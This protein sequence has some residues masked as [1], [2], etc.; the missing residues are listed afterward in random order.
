MKIWFLETRPQF[1]LLSVVL[2]F[3][4]AS[5]AWY[6]SQELGIP[7]NLGYAFLAGFGLL[8]AHI[9]VNTLNDYFDYRSGVDLETRRTPFSGGSGV[10]PAALLKP[11]QV[12]WLGI[13]SFLLAIPI[14]IYFV[15]VSGWLLLPLLLI[16]AVCI[17]LS[18][19]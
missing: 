6:E 14:G 4:G 8:L 2:A 10:L 19:S 9:S 11:G 12:F 18:S 16:A 7:F 1:L 17:L 13:G 5:I 15:I 3:L